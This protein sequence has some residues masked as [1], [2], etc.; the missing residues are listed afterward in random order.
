MG[1]T[2]S[3]GG[4]SL[5]GAV[6]I[7]RGKWVEDDLLN[8]AINKTEVCVYRIEMCIELNLMTRF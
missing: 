7:G 5:Q 4:G 3:C 8:F 2:R 1:L 6:V